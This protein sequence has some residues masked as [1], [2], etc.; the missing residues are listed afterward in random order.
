MLAASL[1]TDLDTWTRLLGCHDDTELVRAEP[2]TMRYRLYHVPATLARHPRRCLMRI[3]RTWSY[4]DAF[5]TCWDR[6]IALPVPT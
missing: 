1:A 6:L 2:V 3:D 4:K 5:T